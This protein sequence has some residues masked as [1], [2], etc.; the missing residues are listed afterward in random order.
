MNYFD[1]LQYKI[2][3]YKSHYSK[4][5]RKVAIKLILWNFGQ[6]FKFNLKGIFTKKPKFTYKLDRI[7]VYISGGLGDILINLNYCYYLLDYLKDDI[8][9]ID[10]YAKNTCFVKD[11]IG[12][13]FFDIY[14]I[15]EWRNDDTIYLLS[16][17]V[18]RYPLIV[19]NNLS[20]IKNSPP[21]LKE[22]IKLYEDFY[23]TNKKL[24]YKTP[25]VD[26]LS[27]QYSIINKQNRIQQPDIYSCLGIHGNNYKF[28]PSIIDE[29]KIL[30]ELNLNNQ[31]FITLNRGVDGT[32][33]YSESTKLYPTKYYN[34]LVELIKNE[35]KEYKIVQLGVS[36]ERCQLIQGVD[37]NLLGKTSLNQL[38]AILKNSILHIDGE[39]GMVHLRKSLNGGV[40]V[41][42][43]GPTSPIFY[44][45]TDNINIFSN[46]CPLNCEWINDNWSSFCINKKN[47]HICMN[48]IEP[49]TIF[50]EIKKILKG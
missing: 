4:K 1:K 7:A 14:S 35:F 46:A 41:V 45:Y 39:G 32:N 23:Q 2:N 21:K 34:K 28:S 47:N 20:L 3:K 29:N 42:I 12:N 33:I 10:I 13:T 49:N 27:N 9:N 22:L 43:F 48:S 50:E 36:V 6:L 24:V 40:S 26:G 19:K 8:A 31:K 37:V 5:Y 16:I 18:D 38:K 17:Q 25:S 30:I 44:G 15:D 11:I